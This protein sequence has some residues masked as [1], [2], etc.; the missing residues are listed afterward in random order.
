MQEPTP[1]P[2]AEQRDIDLRVRLAILAQ[3]T[4]ALYFKDH[5][6]RA[7]HDVLDA[8]RREKFEI[9]RELSERNAREQERANG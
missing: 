3:S 9:T 5:L 6:T 4:S 2:V 1:V 7:D 8:W